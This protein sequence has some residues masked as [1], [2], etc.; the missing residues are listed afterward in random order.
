MGLLLKTT[1]K[2]Q[3]IQNAVACVLTGA[4]ISDHMTPVLWELQWL[5]ICLCAQFKVLF[6]TY[7][8]WVWG[9]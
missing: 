8:I 2:L 7:M 6:L 9:A 4:R 1:W 3:L 5:P